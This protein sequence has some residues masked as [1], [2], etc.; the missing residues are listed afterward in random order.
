MSDD[1]NKNQKDLQNMDLIQ[2]LDNP[3]S[4]LIFYDAK[5]L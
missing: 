4:L 5:L 3:H 2:I 1:Q